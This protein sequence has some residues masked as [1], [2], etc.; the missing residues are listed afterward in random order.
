M[1]NERPNGHEW[2][3][4]LP[5]VPGVRHEYVTVDGVGLHVAE[6][7]EGDP[8]VLLHGFPQHWYIWRRFFPALVQRYRVIAPDFRGSGWS[9]APPGRYDKETL[10]REILGLLDE[11]EVDEFRAVGHDWGAW[12]AALMA[13]FEPKRV[14]RLVMMSQ[15]LPF[16]RLTPR[17][18]ANFWHLWH[19]QVM[20]SPVIWRRAVQ[21]RPPFGQAIFTWL[22]AD[23]W[24]ADE[25]RIFLAQYQQPERARAAHE[26]Y[27]S[28]GRFDMPQTFRG[29]YRRLAPLQPPT[30]L[31]YGKQDN[32]VQPVHFQGGERYARDLTVEYLDCGHAITEELPELVLKRTQKFLADG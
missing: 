8:V 9:D 18:L 11:L 22:H 21:A 24:S 31:L 10:A 3:P 7:G 16:M 12:A 5:E 2:N 19:G 4:A 13:L 17:W 30:L 14:Q 23:R 28:V 27:R 32:T 20:G 25:R 1:T 29:R 26:L 15:M 6:A